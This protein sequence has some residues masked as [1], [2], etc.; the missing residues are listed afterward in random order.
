MSAQFAMKDLGDLYYFL[1]IEVM[2][3]SSRDTMTLTQ[4]K[5]TTDLLVK[6]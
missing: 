2:L 1:G 3:S 6:A 4:Q 5:Y